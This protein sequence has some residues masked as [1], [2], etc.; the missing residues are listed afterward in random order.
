MK[1]EISFFWIAVGCYGVSAFSYVI[2]LMAR[3]ESLLNL[4]MALSAVGLIC[5][6]ATV[7]IRWIT[8]RVM[9]LIEISET[10]SAGVLVAVLIFLII[11][12]S[13]GRLKATGVLVMPVCF[14]LLGWAGSLMKDIGGTLPPSLQ[15][16]WLW[17]HIIG[18]SIG[19]SGV[20]TAAALGLLFLLKERNSGG[21][22]EKIPNLETL[23]DLGYRFI[24][25]GF[26]MLGVM[27][28]SGSLWS[29]QV[30]GSYWNWDPVE[31]WSLIT[32]LTY[33]I[34]LHLR[35]SLG[36]RNRRLAIYALAALGVMII[37]YWGIPFVKENFHTGFRIEH[38]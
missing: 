32:W 38:K 29:N 7:T 13:S 15:S 2:G 3:K 21:V 12:F 17:V 18:A 9:P 19:F 16:Q 24:S 37:S 31:V 5:H 27:L 14:I 22:Y 28:V 4:G 23:D 1:P 36:W 11:Q 26:L 6:T 8:G 34:Y 35:I 33:G 25:G 10:L 30:K 20:L